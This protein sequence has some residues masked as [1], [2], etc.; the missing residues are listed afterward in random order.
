MEPTQIAT[1]PKEPPSIK[2]LIASDGFKDQL[3]KALPAHLSPDRFARIA[4]TAL[5][6]T[7]KLQEC[8]QTSLF[9]CLLDL[10]ALGL[11]PDGRNA[12]LIPYGKECT[13]LID[14]K[15]LMALAKRSGDVS[16]WSATSVCEEDKFTWSN[17]IVEHE[18]NFRKPRGKMECVYSRVT[19]K[20]GAVDYEVMTVEECEA[21]RKRSRAGTSGPWVTDF[22]EMCKKTVIRRHSKRLTLSPEFIHAL[23][24]DDDKLEEKIERIVKA[25]QVPLN[26]FPDALEITAEKEEQP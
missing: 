23:A 21:I 13:L 6:R 5:T 1:A 22:E 14:Y 7:P 2:S 16:T 11:E 20:D 9:R 25:R 18:V 12:H 17:G 15:G 19:L 4:I 26:P 24:V 10:S 8:T 3:S